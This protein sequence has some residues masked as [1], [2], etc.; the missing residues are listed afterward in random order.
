MLKIK[1]I[2]V[3]S[4]EHEVLQ[5]LSLEVNKHE[6]HAFIGPEHAGKTAL[7]Y[8]LAGLPYVD[9]TSGTITYKNKKLTKQTMDERSLNGIAAVFQ[10]PVELTNITNWDLM[11]I[12][13][14]TRGDKVI[15]THKAHYDFLVQQLELGSSHGDKTADSDSL[16]WAEAIKNELLIMFM[17]N[18]SLAIIDCIDE[19]LSPTDQALAMHTIKEFAHRGDRATLIFSRNKEILQAVEPTHVHIMVN[20]SIVLSGGAELLQRIEEDGHPELSTS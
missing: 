12:I 7:V 4:E 2:T 6:I 3:T 20:G 14:E 16:S 17:M 18:P 10:T 5:N 19:K 11:K 8:A 13:I 9:V 1:N 15:D